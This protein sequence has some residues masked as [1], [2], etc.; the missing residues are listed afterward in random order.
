MSERTRLHGS[1][2]RAWMAAMAV[3]I[4]FAIRPAGAADIERV[5]PAPSPIVAV[6]GS[7]LLDLY[8]RGNR[9]QTAIYLESRTRRTIAV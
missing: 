6:L 2:C 8:Q 5:D 3:L 7:S 9:S 4:A 1:A